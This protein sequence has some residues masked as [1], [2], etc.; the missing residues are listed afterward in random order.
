MKG[1]I[2]CLTLGLM[3]CTVNA[4]QN[5]SLIIN[6]TAAITGPEISINSAL[7]RMSDRRQ[8][9]KSL[10]VP[11]VLITYGFISLGN[12]RLKDLNQKVKEEVWTEHP[13]QLRHIDDIIEFAPA[14]SV[15]A[16]NLAGIHG[17][18]NLRDRTMIYLLSDVM[19]RV[20]VSSL[21]KITHQLRPDGSD[22]ASF[23][24]GHAAH[25]FEAAE[26][27]RQEYKD[28]S[29]WYGIAGYA[30]AVATGYLRIYNNK[31][32]LADVLAGAGFGMASSKI[33][34]WLYPKIKKWLFK[35]RPV[36]TMVLPVYRDKSFGL[37]IV[38]E[39]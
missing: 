31:H 22:H 4:Q 20:F 37:A 6:K 8:K 29:P 19:T 2:I 27:L 35:E 11:S 25:A 21:K 34:Y 15:Y 38:K 13:H 9:I 24:S 10:V 14:V 30:I 23:P 32:Y 1:T 18:N 39:F 5:D 36:H 3:T 12:E 17:K 33:S 7:K 16:L 28:V 26:F